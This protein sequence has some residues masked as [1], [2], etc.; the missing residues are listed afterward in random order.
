M[1]R[2]AATLAAAL[3][4]GSVPALAQDK[5]ADIGMGVFT[6]TSGPAAAYG[7]PGR[8]AAELMIE[9]I[10]A[11]GGIGGVPIKPTYV[12]EAQGG[13]GVVSEFRRLAEDP[14]MDVMVAALSSG[15]CMALAPVAD[16]LQMPMVTWNCDTH[17]LF[18]N[19]THD[20][21]FRPNSSTIPEFVAYAAY[22]SATDPEATRIAIINP[23]Y[24]F[25]HDAAQ[26]FTGAMKAFN[27]DVEVVAELF[28][29]LGTASFN[30][31]ISRI[32]A[33]RPDVIFSNLWGGDLEN[34][35]RQASARG[36]FRNS[37]V[38]LAL[39]ESVL[40]RTDLPDGVI[41]GVLGDGWW[42]SPD[43]QA[44][45]ETKAFVAAYKEK[46]GEYP[47]FPAMKMANTILAVKAAYEKAIE[48]SD[49]WPTRDDLRDALEGLQVD[50][51][52]GSVT[53]R[54]D[55]DGLVDQVVG[56]TEPTDDYDFPIIGEMARYPAEK[57]TPPVGEDPMAWIGTLSPDFVSSLPAPGSYK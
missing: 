19:E 48:A 14:E 35:I 6:F 17:Q 26:I 40:Q 45:E 20:Y 36:L 18:L 34:F 9:Q 50:N 21:V 47:V 41:V 4:A 2:F 23:D 24:A 10:N 38:I 30:T 5:P 8:N 1:R 32:A 57:I 33:A 22:L 39:G 15:N 53:I 31:E 44:N 3:V 25:G 13:E 11:D 42:M 49:G 12:D 54:E 43:A 28:P 29:K 27:P 55:H 37:K 46:F 7:M 16:Q 52:T 51:L 56:V